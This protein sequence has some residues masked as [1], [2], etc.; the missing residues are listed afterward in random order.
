MITSDAP[1]QTAKIFAFPQREHT[2]SRATTAQKLA[3]MEAASRRVADAALGSAWY[4]E[5]AIEDERRDEN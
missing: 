2:K 1:R 5:A 4:H 3:A